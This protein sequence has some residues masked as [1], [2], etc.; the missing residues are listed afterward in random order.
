MAG[1][2]LL[3]TST[4]LNAAAAT[5]MEAVAQLPAALAACCRTVSGGGS[6]KAAAAG[7]TASLVG[8]YMAAFSCHLR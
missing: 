8:Q 1:L 7:V 2:P 6:G 3:V 5:A 4:P